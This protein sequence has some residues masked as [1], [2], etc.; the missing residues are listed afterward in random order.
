VGEVDAFVMF[1]ILEEMILVFPFKCDVGY[2][3]VIDSLYN[4]EVF[5]LYSSFLQS[6][7]MKGC[8]FCQRLFLHLLR[9][10]CDFS[11]YTVK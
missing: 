11:G 10:S 3:F 7:I 9:G 4:V 5:F 2:S 6:L 1:L 8:E